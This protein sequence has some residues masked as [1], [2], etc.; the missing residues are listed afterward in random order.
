MFIT[1][2]SKI[3]KTPSSIK[4]NAVV[5]RKKEEEID[6]SPILIVNNLKN[7][8]L[9]D[10]QKLK[11]L[12]WTFTSPRDEFTDLLKDQMTCANVNKSLMANM[13]HDDFRYHLKAIETL[14]E[15]LPANSKALISS[16]D[17]ILKWVSLRF[18]D[19]NPSVL[20]KGLEYLNL[21]FEML[22]E[23]GYVLAENEGSCFI[24]HLLI[25][26]ISRSRLCNI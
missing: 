6:T 21:V 3:Q 23:N 7:Q 15:D 20:L 16:L 5:S 19:T 17:L 22:G 2:N 26:V 24:P 18:Y 14:L 1:G 12:K 9:L 8:R 13:F 25:K 11:V 10:E 4:V